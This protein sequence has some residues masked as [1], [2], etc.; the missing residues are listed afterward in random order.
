MWEIGRFKLYLHRC[1]HEFSCTRNAVCLH[2]TVVTVHVICQGLIPYYIITRA[3]YWDMCIKDMWSVCLQIY[4]NNRICSKGIYFLRKIQA[5]QKQWTSW[6]FLGLRVR[7]SRLLFFFAKTHREIS[8]SALGCLKLIHITC[9][10]I[11]N[12]ESNSLNQ[13]WR[14]PRF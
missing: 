10:F 1:I 3:T 2:D 9:R 14:D 4:K 7:F 5:S 6:E 12:R 8:K 13:V 11:M